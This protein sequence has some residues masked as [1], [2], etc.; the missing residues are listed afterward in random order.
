MR[1]SDWARQQGVSYKTAW[2]WYHAGRLPVPAYQTDTGTILVGRPEPDQKSAAIYARVETYAQS[3]DLD[4]QVERLQEW[5]AILE[6]DVVRVEREIGSLW[7]PKLIDL[8]ATDSIS[9]IIVE[10]RGRL[11]EDGSRLVDAALRGSGRRLL[12]MDPAGARR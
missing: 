2:R 6:L 1:L 7:Q 11:C 12:T 4:R 5:A 10:D 3:P 9:A 8:L